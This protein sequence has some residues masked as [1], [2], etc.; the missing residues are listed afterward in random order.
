MATFKT[1]EDAIAFAWESHAT[2]II[3][4]RKED[5]TTFWNLAIPAN[6]L[7]IQ[8]LR[9]SLRDSRCII[10][11]E[12]DLR[13][14]PLMISALGVEK[15]ALELGCRLLLLTP[16]PGGRWMCWIET[17]SEN[18]A[19]RYPRLM[20]TYGR[21]REYSVTDR[22]FLQEDKHEVLYLE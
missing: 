5:G 4:G 22:Y 9:N 13:L 18:L 21:V 2:Y 3:C 17:T 12:I 15:L 19:D 11:E 16:V 1:K 10:E 20:R 6:D 14:S 7:D 8:R